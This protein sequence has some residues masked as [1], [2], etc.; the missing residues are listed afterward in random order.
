MDRG[1]DPSDEPI[2]VRLDEYALRW[3]PWEDGRLSIQ[4]GQFATVVGNA[5]KRHLSWD[6][7]FINAPLIYENV[8][9]IYDTEPPLYAGSFGSIPAGRSTNTTPVI[10]G[11]SYATG[12]SVSGRIGKF[13]YAAEIKTPDCHHAPSHGM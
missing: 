7:P 4:G 3:T 11:P 5:V 13:D 9:R 6:N 1:F 10:W 8:T 12:L 2:G